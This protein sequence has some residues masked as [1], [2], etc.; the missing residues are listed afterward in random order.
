ME[1]NSIIFFIGGGFVFGWATANFIYGRNECNTCLV[2]LVR[3]QGCNTC[4]TDHHKKEQAE[5]FIRSLPD[6]IREKLIAKIQAGQ[7]KFVKEIQKGD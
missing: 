6:D 2:A 1:L 3:G 5:I 7:M 4:K